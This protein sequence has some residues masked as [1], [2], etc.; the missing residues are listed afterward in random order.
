MVY[1]RHLRLPIPISALQGIVM[2]LYILRHAWAAEAGDPRWPA[3]RLRPLTDLGRKRF[4]E[5]ASK[6]VERDM[7]PSLI[8]TSPLLRCV[9]TAET[10][11]AEIHHR[12]EIV[13]LDALQPSSDFE[14]LIAWTSQ[15]VTAGHT[16]IAWVGHAPDVDYFAC[17]L[18]GATTAMIR[19]AKGAA[20]AIRFEGMPRSGAGELRWLVTAKI[21]GC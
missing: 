17:R 6:L 3:D 14:A 18:I 5:V 8:A 10:L 11:A 4:A 1:G 13:E 12:P 19:F 21:L 16:S 9:Q 15:Q 2:D 20:A 7:K